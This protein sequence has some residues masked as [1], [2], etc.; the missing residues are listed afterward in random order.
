[1]QAAQE[2]WS[3][4][5]L[6]SYH[7]YLNNYLA[8]AWIASSFEMRLKV[9][10]YIR[11]F[12]NHALNAEHTRVVQQLAIAC[13][14]VYSST[15]TPHHSQPLQ[16][17]QRRWLGWQCFMFCHYDNHC[18]PNSPNTKQGWKSKG[19]HPQSLT[20]NTKAMS[21]LGAMVVAK[22][23]HCSATKLNAHPMAVNCKQHN[24]GSFCMHCRCKTSK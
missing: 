11:Y 1:M 14:M 5:L 12:S 3:G 8:N 15:S 13:S 23:T 4:V 10:A 7:N 24:S 22:K 16:R 18:D 2:R 6:S 17:S 20:A 19:T 9:I 21:W